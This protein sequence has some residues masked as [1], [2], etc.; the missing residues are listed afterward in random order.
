M[1]KIFKA[2][3]LLLVSIL[4]LAGC[5][6]PEE[7]KTYV[8]NPNQATTV[9]IALYYKDDEVTKQTAHTVIQLDSFTDEQKELMKTEMEQISATYQGIEGVTQKFEYKDNSIVEDVEVDYTKV[10][11]KTLRSKK[12]VGS[13][14]SGDANATKVSFK[15]TSEMLLKSGFKEK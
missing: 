10:D 1:N 12:L 13:D 9:E 2:L 14:F 6:K 4:I 11:L 7:S 8:A 5:S 15:Q 3:S